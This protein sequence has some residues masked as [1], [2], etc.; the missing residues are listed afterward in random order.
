[1][2]NNQEAG[3]DRR[4]FLGLVG[5]GSAA[6]FLLAVQTAEAGGPP[7]NPDA[8]AAAAV[9]K[10]VEGKRGAAA[11]ETNLFEMEETDFVYVG[12]GHPDFANYILSPECSVGA[13]GVVGYSQSEEIRRRVIEGVESPYLKGENRSAVNTDT[14]GIERVTAN[15]VEYV[16]LPSGYVMFTADALNLSIGLM[17]IDMKT[18]DTA[19]A[20]GATNVKLASR[21]S[22]HSYVVVVR[23]PEND[24]QIDTDE[25]HTIKVIGQPGSVRVTRFPLA[26]QHAAR[27]SAEHVA[28]QVVSASKK[29]TSGQDGASRVTIAVIDPFNGVWHTFDWDNATNAY[30]AA[31]TNST[32]KPDLETLP[33][34]SDLAQSEDQF[35]RRT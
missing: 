29:D 21:G 17:T 15:P 6:A 4:R 5:G 3:L 25:S 32:R 22:D 35:V 33:K 28:E 30:T 34:M 27:F 23:G 19:F 31:D 2:N 1:M 11:V 10:N 16:A 18:G 7:V 14:P 8:A 26:K 9:A 24:N 20:D 12:E 13:A